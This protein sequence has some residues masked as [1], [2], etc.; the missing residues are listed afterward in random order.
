MS[1]GVHHGP[2]VPPPQ[3]PGLASVLERNIRALEER[4]RREEAEADG[5]TRIANAITRFTGSMTFVYL[6]LVLVGAWVA[7]NAGLIPGVPRFDPTFVIL[8]TWA[9]VEAIFLSTFVLI[10][11][12]RAA[13]AADR[14]ADLHLQ[15]GLL[16]EH[17]VT[18]LL[19]LV[20]AVAHKLEVVEAQ[21]PAI[22]ELQRDVA[23]ESVLDELES[24]RSSRRAS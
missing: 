1:D 20:R 17:E 8:A 3:P 22:D 15:I 9:S 19:T 11:Q 2:T 5:Q 4:R 14:R 23:P 21:D 12:N 24:D 13:E 6:H 16:S 7:V 10:S 18:R